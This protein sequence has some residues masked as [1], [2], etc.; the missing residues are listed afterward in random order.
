[1]LIWLLKQLT[2]SAVE[3]CSRVQFG[4]VAVLSSPLLDDFQNIAMC[5]VGIRPVC[6]SGSNCA[7]RTGRSRL[8]EHTQLAC[9]GVDRLRDGT[10]CHVFAVCVGLA[11]DGR[12]SLHLLWRDVVCGVVQDLAVAGPTPHRGGRRMGCRSHTSRCISCHYL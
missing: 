5:M 4:V 6:V 11:L 3:N 1:M 8:W 2:L 9:S 7:H 12:L 10:G